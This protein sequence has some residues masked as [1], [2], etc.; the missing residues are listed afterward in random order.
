[1]SQDKDYHIWTIQIGAWRLAR[2]N[3]I[4]LIDVTVK[5]GINSFAPTWENLRAYKAGLMSKEEYTRQYYDK[6][7]SSSDYNLDE[8]RKL[9][10][11]RLMALACYCKAGDYCHRH[12]FAPLVITYLQSLGKRVI[13]HGELQQ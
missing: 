4:A 11:N 13:F 6:V 12:L 8:W 10:D 2:D 9:A 1:M 7:I 3:G 5:S